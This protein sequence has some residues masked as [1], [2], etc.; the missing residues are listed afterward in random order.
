[1]GSFDTVTVSTSGISSVYVSGVTQT[2]NVELGGISNLYLQPA[3][4]DAQIRGRW[5]DH[6]T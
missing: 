1:M 4:Q 2:V 5:V 3:S 6:I